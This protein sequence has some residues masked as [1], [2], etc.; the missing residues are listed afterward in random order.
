ME[1]IL[2]SVKKLL[3]LA[4][5]YTPFDVDVTMHINSTFMILNQL[6]V[7]P[8]EGFAIKDAEAKWEDYLEDDKKIEATKSYMYAK[9]KLIFDPPT[10]AA[11]IEALKGV[12]AEYEWRLF[13]AKDPYPINQS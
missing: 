13:V 3:G 8:A 6:G 9:V 1:S 10:S 5:G 11:H 4:E 7:G 2:T 12:I